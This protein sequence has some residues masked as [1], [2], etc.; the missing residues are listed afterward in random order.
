MVVILGSL[1]FGILWLS[2]LKKVVW[3]EEPQSFNGGSVDSA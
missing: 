1:F 3:L 2:G